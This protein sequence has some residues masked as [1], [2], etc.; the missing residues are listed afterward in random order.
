M[1]GET[2]GEFRVND[3]VSGADAVLA[4]RVLKHKMNIN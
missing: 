2:S 1:E 3:P 4:V